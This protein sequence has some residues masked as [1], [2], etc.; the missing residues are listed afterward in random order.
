MSPVISS[1]FAAQVFRPERFL[2]G[3][4]EAASRHPFAYL[5]FGVGPRKCIG[6][7]FAMEE[8]TKP[9]ASNTECA[10]ENQRYIFQPISLRCGPHAEFPV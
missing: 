9:S 6:Y 7:K 8:V 10:V 5:P 4:L 3:S 1:C 2:D